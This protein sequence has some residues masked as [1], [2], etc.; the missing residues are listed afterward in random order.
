MI[1]LSDIQQA[2]E[3][4][5]PYTLH[6]PLLRV[7]VLDAIVGCKVYAK[8][9]CTQITGSFK[10]RGAMNCMQMLS[11]EELARGVVC[12]SSGNHA[13]A[14]AYTAKM[15]GCSA[16]IVMPTT[17]NPV[18]LA[19]VRS[20]GAEA[21]L[22]DI[23]DREIETQRIVEEEGRVLVHAFADPRV[24]AGQGTAGLEIMSDE[25][26]IDAIVVPIG[27][28]GLVSGIAIA[29]KGIKP[30]VKIFGIENTVTARYTNC[31][32]QNKLMDLDKIGDTI[33]D[34]TRGNHTDAESLEII[35]AYVD[36]ILLA[37][38][39]FIRKAVRNVFEKAHIYAEP[40]S[41]MGIAVAMAGKLPVKPDDK[42]AFVLSGGNCDLSVITQIL[43]E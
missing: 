29:A 8:L 14:V 28:G 21:V 18:K 22:V 33:A 40:S 36:E 16:K 7:P 26:D 30:D 1:N 2:Q 12:P 43:S 19:N 38:E 17:C 42:V 37:E 24:K 34:G 23:M 15:L 3:R 9:D 5:A 39:S 41:C 11:K 31:L 25:P 27:G 20:Y 35:K 32:E 4:I 6:T 13:Q 10:I